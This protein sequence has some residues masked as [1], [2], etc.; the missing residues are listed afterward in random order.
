MRS[1][2]RASDTHVT[3][4]KRHEPFRLRARPHQHPGKPVGAKFGQAHQ[5]PH[6][7][8]PTK[9]LL[10]AANRSHPVTPRP[11]FEEKS[12]AGTFSAWLDVDPGTTA[13]RAREEAT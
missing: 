8:H 6:K 13:R 7:Q 2:T 4:P 9:K 11:V 10:F 3:F 12:S 1:I 5:K